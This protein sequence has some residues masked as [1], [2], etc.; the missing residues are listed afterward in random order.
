MGNKYFVTTQQ[1]YQPKRNPQKFNEKA[2]WIR[3]GKKVVIQDYINENATG[4]NFYE[5]LERLGSVE[6]TISYM[7]HNGQEIYGDFTNAISLENME[8]KRIELMNVWKRLPYDVRES[9]GN[10][11]EIF[12]TNGKNYFENLKKQWEIQKNVQTGNNNETVPDKETNSGTE[13]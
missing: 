2:T 1:I 13:A 9:F 6:N 10:N 4:L 8:K 7:K 12:C 3:Q 11:F 5:N